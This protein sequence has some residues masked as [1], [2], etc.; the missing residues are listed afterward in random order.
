M[1]QITVGQ[2]ILDHPSRVPHTDVYSFTH[3]R[4]ALDFDAMAGAGALCQDLR[5]SRAGAG[6]WCWPS[7]AIAATFALFTKFLSRQAEREHG[8]LVF[9]AGR[10]GVERCRICWRGRMC[11]R[12]LSW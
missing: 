4:P 10:I 11:W 5:R 2:W 12:C 6:R 8:T 9:V 1:W 7:A 3:A